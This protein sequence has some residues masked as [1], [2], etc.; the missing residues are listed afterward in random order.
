MILLAKSRNDMIFPLIILRPQNIIALAIS[1]VK[2]ISFP[3]GNIIVTKKKSLLDFSFCYLERMM[4]ILQSFLLLK[5]YSFFICFYSSSSLSWAPPCELLAS[6]FFSLSL[7]LFF[8][9]FHFIFSVLVNLILI[10]IKI[11]THPLWGEFLFWSGW[12]ESNSQIKLGKLT[13]YH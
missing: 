7:F 5:L 4:R 8:I 1:F 11:K 2:R 10:S 6:P 9:Y 12:W 13:F 3:L